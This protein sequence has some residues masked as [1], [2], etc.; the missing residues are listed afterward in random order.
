[1]GCRR[2]ESIRIWN[3]LWLTDEPL[4][5]VA[6]NIDSINQELMVHQLLSPDRTCDEHI[7]RNLLSNHLSNEI[8]TKIMEVNIPKNHF[9]DRMYWKESNDGWF[10]TKSSVNMIH[11]N[12]G[13]K[14][15]DL[16]W[17]WNLDCA[18]KI[19][20]FLWRIS[21][22]GLQT[23]GRLQMRRIVVPMHCE[24]CNH[25]SEDFFH[26]FMDCNFVKDII[27]QSKASL[28]NSIFPCNRNTREE[29]DILQEI[30]EIV[31]M[32]QMSILATIWWSIWY[33][34]NQIVFNNDNKDKPKV[35]E[36]IE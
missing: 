5:K 2:W 35:V 34:R 13:H 4:L 31:G 24:F 23:K 29:K 3:D 8:I 12:K 30:K 11:K 22:G 32:K 10:S 28:F 18:P 20:H 17:I 36:F 7:I 27:Q 21:K 1:M 15:S 19:K 33:F 14:K 6:T 16:H 26:L 9:Q 25:H